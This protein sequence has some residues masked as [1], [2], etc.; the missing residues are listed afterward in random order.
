MF[1]GFSQMDLQHLDAL[2]DDLAN[3]AYC[4]VQLPYLLQ[5]PLNLPKNFLSPFTTLIPFAL[6]MV[7]LRVFVLWPQ[8]LC[9]EVIALLL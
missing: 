3:T 2:I 1:V 4:L 8:N 9:V 7:I 6:S 5:K